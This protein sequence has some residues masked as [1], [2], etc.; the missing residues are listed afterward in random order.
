[1]NPQTHVTV[2]DD[3][4]VV[5]DR[6]NLKNQESQSEKRPLHKLIFNGLVRVRIQGVIGPFSG[7]AYSF[8]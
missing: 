5:R 1:M 6:G 3:G 7:T 8:S 2:S 4:C